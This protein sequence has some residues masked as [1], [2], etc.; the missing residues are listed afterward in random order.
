MSE[1]HIRPARAEDVA[2]IH[3]II[4]DAER[5]LSDRG[6]PM[7]LPEELR[8]EP[9]RE[10]VVAGMYQVAEL[11]GEVVGTLRFQLEDAEYWPDLAPGDGAFVH[12]LAVRRDHAGRGVST[13]LL[14]WAV[15]RAREVGRGHL[16]LDCDAHRPRL[17]D[18]YEGFGFRFHSYRQVGPFYV[19][20][21]EMETGVPA[22]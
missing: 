18:F 5:W 19:A 22:G 7:W 21:Y 10:H 1:I 15:A 6:M 4:T 13:A 16:R 14:T 3:G 12:R 8:V 11:D 2:A 17:R 20:R 9:I